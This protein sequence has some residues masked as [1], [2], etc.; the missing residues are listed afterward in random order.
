MIIYIALTSIIIALIIERYFYSRDMNR[1]INDCFKAL[2]SRNANEYASL[3]GL[4]NVK[5]TKREE[6]DARPIEDISDKEWLDAIKK[7]VWNG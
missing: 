4:D 1:Q 6:P 7:G 3:K 5:T 2:L